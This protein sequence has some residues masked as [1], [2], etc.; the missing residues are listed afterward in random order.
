MRREDLRGFP[1]TLYNATSRARSVLEIFP[2]VGVGAGVAGIGIG[3]GFGWPFR[4]AYGPPRA[5]CGPGIGIA[6]V[7]AGYGQG[8]LGRRFGKDKRSSDAMRSL[9]SIERKIEKS[10]SGFVRL[11]RRSAKD[12]V[13]KI[14]STGNAVRRNS[15]S[16]PWAR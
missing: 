15:R 2:P 6:V 9:R 7:G 3:C 8:F 16:L 5:F 11:L 14:S 13:E 4:A 12:A 1:R 10:V